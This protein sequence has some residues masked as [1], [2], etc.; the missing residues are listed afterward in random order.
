MQHG[1]VSSCSVSFCRGCCAN[2]AVLLPLGPR[3][4]SFVADSGG[5]GGCMQDPGPS[6]ALHLCPLQY[7]VLHAA[8]S[9]ATAQ[10][11]GR[12]TARPL[13]FQ[14]SHQVCSLPSSEH[15]ARQLRRSG[16]KPSLLHHN[17]MMST[18]ASPGVWHFPHFWRGP[19][20]VA[21]K[22]RSLLAGHRPECWQ[23]M[24]TPSLAG[25]ETVVGCRRRRMRRRRRSRR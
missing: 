23:K 8:I 5:S 3:V 21:R 15:E 2:A 22:G 14:R 10:A 6:K 16:S 17:R 25:T 20:I 13:P 9:P 12:A 11:P 18:A 19:S 7:R 1:P 24:L 4:T